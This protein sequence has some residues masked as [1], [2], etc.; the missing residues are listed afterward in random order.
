MHK[1][2]KAIFDEEKVLAEA[3]VIYGFTRDQVQF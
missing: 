1:D 3:A 2:I